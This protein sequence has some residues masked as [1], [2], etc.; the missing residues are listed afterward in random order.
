MYNSTTLQAILHFKQS[1]DANLEQLAIIAKET[2]QELM[3][4][5][6]GGRS[7]QLRSMVRNG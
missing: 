7:V 1:F 5:L 3:S 4:H 6:K 2:S